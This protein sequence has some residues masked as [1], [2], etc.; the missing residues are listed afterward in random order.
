MAVCGMVSAS[1]AP[2]SGAREHLAELRIGGRQF[3]D[4]MTPNAP[5]SL[6]HRSGRRIWARAQ[7]EAEMPGT[8]FAPG[9]GTDG[10][11]PRRGRPQG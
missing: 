7:S 2:F 5:A 6:A 1:L 11:S 9:R 10:V 4:T 8:G 3:D